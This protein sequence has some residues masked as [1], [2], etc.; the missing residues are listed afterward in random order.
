MPWGGAG[1]QQKPNNQDASL[2]FLD[3]IKRS[4]AYCPR[5]E[6]RRVCEGRPRGTRLT[7]PTRVSRGREGTECEAPPPRWREGTTRGV[8]AS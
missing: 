4:F 1:Q 2:Q 3:D 7:T 6:E 8:G 5:R